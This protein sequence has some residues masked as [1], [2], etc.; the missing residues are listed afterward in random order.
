MTKK[1]LL[2]VNVNNSN[3]VYDLFRQHYLDV[4]STKLRY[5]ILAN[6]KNAANL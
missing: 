3:L 1:A 5:C 2:N 4:L 6:F